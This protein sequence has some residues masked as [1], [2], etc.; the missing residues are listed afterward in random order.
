[1]PADDN[2]LSLTQVLEAEHV[3]LHELVS[4]DAS[5]ADTQAALKT[6][7]DRVLK[8]RASLDQQSS[9][10][11]AS[12]PL[13]ED[14]W[15]RIIRLIHNRRNAA[16]C[17]SGGGIRSA[18]FGLGVIQSLARHNLLDEFHYLSTVSGGGY[19]G[20]WLTAWIQHDPL[21]LPGVI[22]HLK[23][24][25]APEAKKGP[26]NPEPQP[27]QHL[28]AYSNYMSPRLGLLSADTWT[29]VATVVRNLILNWFVL[30]PILAAIL[31]IPRV[32]IPVVRWNGL[33]SHDW[34]RWATLGFGSLCVIWAI[35]FVGMHRP[36]A[37]HDGGGSP[38][39][40]NGWGPSQTEFLAKCLL[41][42]M[43]AAMVLTTHWQ[44]IRVAG[45][46]YA[47]W[48]FLIFGTVM[49]FSSWLIYAARLR[50]LK[51]WKEALAVLVCGALTGLLLWALANIIYFSPE[52]YVCLALPMFISTFLLGATLFT[53]LISKL[54]ADPDSSVPG[55]QTWSADADREWWA[56]MGAWCLIVSAC[57]A[58]F[59]LIAIF[60]PLLFTKMPR[61]VTAL[62]GVSGVITILIGGGSKTPGS[63][64]KKAGASIAALVADKGAVLAAPIFGA[65]ILILISLGTSVLTRPVIDFA[66]G[67]DS[68]HWETIPQPFAL[69]EAAPFS[70]NPPDGPLHH[71]KLVRYSP[72]LVDFALMFGLLALGVGMAFFI[73]INKFSLHSMYRD[74]LIRAYL[75]A[76]RKRRPNRFTGFDEA[77]N[78]RMH[79]LWPFNDHGVRKNRLLHV[80]NIALNLVHGDNLAWQ[81]RKA[82]SFTVSPLHSGSSAE[83]VGYRTS[84]D[85]AK[86]V[87][88][89]SLG[90]ALAISGAAVSP[91]MG[92]HSS[93]V[94]AF[95][96]TLFNARLGWW[97]GNPAKEKY[98][99]AYPRFAIGPMFAEAFALTD[100]KKGYVYLSDGG[101]FDNLGLY[102]MVLRRCHFILV[103]DAGQDPDFKA[104]DLGNA[105]RKIR[106][107]LGIPIEFSNPMKI[108]SRGA[109]K[110]GDPFSYF[111]L[112]EIKYSQVD[113][114]DAPQGHI[115][116][117]KPAIYGE[118]PQDVGQYAKENLLF[119]HES[120]ADQFFSESQLE[121]YRAL[122][123]YE[124]NQVLGKR[125]GKP[126]DKLVEELADQLSK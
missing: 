54:D 82:T 24:D 102:E 109:Y 32:C 113:G 67:H 94:V 73:N 84:K 60:G 121:S 114:E 91:N 105:I 49:H 22:T 40:T 65:F 28:R 92:Y 17:I 103:S 104:S 79:K 4:A 10:P 51:R 15:A 16:L 74:R 108:F 27:I 45:W 95:L 122:G 8:K 26:A 123:E 83:G 38:P 46:T 6:D 57:W 12:R 69:L 14:R 13:S 62:G 81:E 36:S 59:S 96:L 50:Q 85:Y 44:W 31:L 53:G 106:I 76:A 33:Q 89:I 93:A 1:M 86:D 125:V 70:V 20:S 119:P 115:L 19:V 23:P 117:L 90:T 98:T 29:L 55:K 37:S 64:N 80:V 43:L 42:L 61:I 21:G 75:G 47:W 88:G 71:L 18:T 110:K 77:D 2:P 111:A 118:E 52:P 72:G 5:E 48:Q 11:I 97:I 100:A 34:L 9:P 68:E 3:N 30:I 116:Y 56:R 66:Y 41:P 101:H 39:D 58:V 99:R 124:M 126:F 112:G 35:V 107:D 87:G 7:D 63:D 78:I 120:T 25:P